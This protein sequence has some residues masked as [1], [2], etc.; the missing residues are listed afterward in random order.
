M[1]VIR[2]RT[3]GDIRPVGLATHQNVEEPGRS[4]MGFLANIQGLPPKLACNSHN[5][6]NPSYLNAYWRFCATPKS[7]CGKGDARA[8]MRTMCNSMQ[9]LLD[10]CQVLQVSSKVSQHCTPLAVKRWWVK[11]AQPRCS[12]CPQGPKTLAGR[13]NGDLWPMVQAALMDE[14]ADAVECADCMQQLAG[15]GQELEHAELHECLARLMASTLL[16]TAGVTAPPIRPGCPATLHQPH[17]HCPRPD[18]LHVQ[19]TCPGNHWRQ[20]AAADGSDNQQYLLESRHYK[21]A[22]KGGYVHAQQIVTLEPE[23]LGETWQLLF[24]H[25]VTWGRAAWIQ[26]A[27]PG[28][29]PSE[30]TYTWLDEKARPWKSAEHPTNM[31]LSHWLQARLKTIC[32]Q[33]ESFPRHQLEELK[34][35]T[36][37]EARCPPPP[38]PFSLF[39]CLSVSVSA[40]DSLPF[41]LPLQVLLCPSH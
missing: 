34:T 17:S 27:C 39:L 2:E 22:D 24:K 8:T 11:Y 10:A 18:C 19:R 15:E 3:H 32:Q 28:M 33:S 29:D 4:Y 25:W 5:M 12:T 6:L 41:Q 38:P 14:M 36:L 13:G 1:A 37:Q 30:V 7:L 9:H 31:D 23:L 21:N 20:V 16:A 35:F 26:L 40:S